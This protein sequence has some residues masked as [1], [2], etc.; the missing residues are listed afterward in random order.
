MILLELKIHGKITLANIYGPYEDRAQFY[1]NLKQKILD[2]GNDEVIICGDWNLVINPEIDTEN[3]QHVN[4]PTAIRGVLKLI[5][6]EY[7]FDIYSCINESKVCTWRRHSPD[8]IQA[9][10][11]YFY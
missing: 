8:K 10:L 7:Y 1:N 4:S 6:N 11:D 5:K 2:L 9:R 3:Y